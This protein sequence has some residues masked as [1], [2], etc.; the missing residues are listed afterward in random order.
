MSDDY[1]WD[2]SGPPDPEIAKLEQLLRPLAHDAPLRQ[3]RSRTPWVVGGAF[4]AAAAAVAIYFALPRERAVS[5][6]GSS[7]FPFEGIGGDVACGGGRVA[8]GT[9]PVGATL[10]T[11]DHEA[12]LAI[13]DIGGARLGK[14]TTVR[15]E[16]T[17]SDRHQLALDV[18]SMH[19]KVDAPPRLFAVTTPLTEVVDLGCEYDITIAHGGAGSLTVHDGLVELATKSGTAVVVPEGCTAKIL[20]AQRPGLPICKVTTTA[21][22]Q[23]IHEYDAGDWSAGETIIARASRVDAVVLLALAAVDPKLRSRALTK[24]AE[25]SPPPDA[26]IS[27]ESAASEPAHLATWQDDVLGIY[28]GLFGPDAGRK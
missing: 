25:L 7:G 21:V 8:K 5:C 27:A 16:R 13:A 1:L 3:R 22:T 2:G 23:A 6:A 18:G 19:A 28:F 9:L 17:G 24:L 14:N 4:V 26:E 15:L 10:Q 20:G 12:A 11:W